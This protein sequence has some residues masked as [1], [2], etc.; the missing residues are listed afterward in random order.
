MGMSIVNGK[1][2]ALSTELIKTPPES[3]I[4]EILN[5]HGSPRILRPQLRIREKGDRATFPGGPE[6]IRA[7]PEKR[8]RWKGA[9]LAKK[10][11]AVCR[12]ANWGRWS[13]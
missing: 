3:K 5:R 12:R 4:L 11:A 8:F 10:R 9:V 2:H 1:L 13:V 7:L 6:T